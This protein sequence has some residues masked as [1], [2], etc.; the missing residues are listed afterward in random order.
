M[1]G[2]IDGLRYGLDAIGE[3]ESDVRIL[4]EGHDEL[5]LVARDIETLAARLAAR[6]TLA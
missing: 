6:S 4:T 1:L 2:D 5:S 3:G